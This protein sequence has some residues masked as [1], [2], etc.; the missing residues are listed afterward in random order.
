MRTCPYCQRQYA[1]TYVFCLQDGSTLIAEPAGPA[2]QRTN[3][4]ESVETRIAQVPPVATQPANR[5]ALVVACIIAASVALLGLVTFLL[6]NNRTS[7]TQP[8][9]TASNPPT[10]NVPSDVPSR[11][12]PRNNRP[13]PSQNATENNAP[14][15]TSD[16]GTPA[17]SQAVSETLTNWATASQSHDLEGHLSHYADIVSP[18]YGRNSASLSQVRADRA[19]AYNLFTE[20]NITLSNLKITFP[21]AGQANVILDKTWHFVRPDGRQSNGSVQQQIWLTQNGEQWL[22]TGEKDLRVY[23]KN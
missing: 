15:S 18:Y 21:A 3:R 13:A 8:T 1:D 22:I 20:L 17:A 14:A 19:R 5:R 4:A 2:N 7:A 9:V 23:Y 12:A 6:L 10:N 11:N 16:Y